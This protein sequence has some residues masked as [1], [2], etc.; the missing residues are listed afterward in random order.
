MFFPAWLMVIKEN[1]FKHPK[2]FKTKRQLCSI[3]PK[4]K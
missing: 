3:Y 1:T 4:E 2:F